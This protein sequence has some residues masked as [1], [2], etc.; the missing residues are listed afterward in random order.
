M[1]ESKNKGSSKLLHHIYGAM[2]FGV[3]N[4]GMDIGPFV[5]AV[6]NNANRPFVDSLCRDNPGFLSTQ[7]RKFEEAFNFKDSSEIYSFYESRTS[8]TVVKVSS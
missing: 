5:L 8:P 6:G 3:P 1:F 2:F 4:D 7:R